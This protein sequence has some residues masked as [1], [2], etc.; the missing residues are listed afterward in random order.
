MSNFYK[1]L[2]KPIN[3]LYINGSEMDIRGKKAVISQVSDSSWESQY[4][5]PSHHEVNAL[6]GSSVVYKGKIHIFGLDNI[7]TSGNHYTW[8]GE[9][10][11]LVD[12]GRFPHSMIGC[13]VVVYND[14]IHILGGSTESNKKT[15]NL[16]YTWD[17][18]N[19][20]V[21]L[22]AKITYSVN[23][24]T[25]LVVNNEIHVLGGDHSSSTKKSHSIFNGSSWRKGIALPQQMVGKHM[26]YVTQG[27]DPDQPLEYGKDVLHTAHYNKKKNLTARCFL[28]TYYNKKGKVVE[29]W[30]G[31]SDIGD[32]LKVGLITTVGNIAHALVGKD[33]YTAIFED[34]IGGAYGPYRFKKNLDILP[35]TVDSENP[36]DEVNLLE[37][38]DGLYLIYDSPYTPI[39][40]RK[41]SYILE[42]TEE[43]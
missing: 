2:G 33:H 20:Y 25:A 26:A 5:A 11:E 1:V 6:Y 34:G 30:E 8:D 14:K 39:W 12:S 43:E 4:D 24:S 3:P 13:S 9:N 27:T 23:N 16:H 36:Y 42:I 38:S 17:E 7:E 40:E 15:R 35:F 21:E 41:Q 22:Q 29:S 10:L 28:R 18:D 19:G 37:Y 32:Y 31:D